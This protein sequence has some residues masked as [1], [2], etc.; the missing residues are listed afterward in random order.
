MGEEH[1]DTLRQ[2]AF[3]ALDND[4]G[5]PRSW[6]VPQLVEMVDTLLVRD[7]AVA[8]GALVVSLGKVSLECAEHL[9]QAG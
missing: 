6:R 7:L 5:T 8:P 3:P 2:E 9:V 4:R 1:V